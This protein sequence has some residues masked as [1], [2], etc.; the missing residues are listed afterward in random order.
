MAP[1][2][3]HRK[4]IT[5]QLFEKYLKQEDLAFSFE[6]FAKIRPGAKN[7]DYLVLKDGKKILVEC[8]EIEEG[9]FDNLPAGIGTLD[10]TKHYG[11]LRDRIKGAARQLKPYHAQV[12]HCVVMFGK[13]AGYGIGI[14]D[15]FYAMFGNPIFS[16]PVSTRTGGPAGKISFDLTSSGALR[17][18]NADKSTWIVHDYVSAVAVVESFNA[19]SYYQSKTMDPIM[20]AYAETN[21]DKPLGEQAIEF[22]DH[23][24]KVWKV[25]KAEVPA[26]FRS[27]KKLLYRVR[28]VVNPLSKKP[29]PEGAFSGTWDTVRVPVA[30]EREV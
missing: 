2:S 19:Y 10:M 16:V 14:D 22:L 25:K 4:T 9:P 3:A 8:K 23:Y 13:A 5:D 1:G 12:D 30:A 7:P 28:V 18:S 20:K 11:V 29:L 6:P 17:K 27:P 26:E 21:R 24:R 15:I